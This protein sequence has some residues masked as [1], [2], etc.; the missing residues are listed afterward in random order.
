MRDNHINPKSSR[1]HVLLNLVIDTK[2]LF[3]FDLCGRQKL[4]QY[5]PNKS[6][7]QIL[8]EECKFINNSLH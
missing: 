1:G 4:D 3:L 2:Q 6:K 5:D 8:I 7:D